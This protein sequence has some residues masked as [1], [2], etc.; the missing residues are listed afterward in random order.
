MVCVHGL[1]RSALYMVC[2][3]GMCTCSVY[4]GC[5]HE[6]CSTDWVHG[7]CTWAVYISSVHGLCTWAVYMGFVHKLCTWSLFLSFV[8][9]ILFAGVWQSYVSLSSSS[10]SDWA[11][12]FV[13]V[14]F[15][16]DIMYSLVTVEMRIRITTINNVNNCITSDNYRFKSSTKHD[17]V[18]GMS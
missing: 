7:L 11:Q 17:L 16:C 8:Q 5:V 4:M 15:L 2:L 13:H 12:I 18:K 6:L 9:D 3:H 1:C 14:Q 10:S